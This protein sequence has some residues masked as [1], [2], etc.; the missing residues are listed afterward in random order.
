VPTHFAT[1]RKLCGAQLILCVRWIL[2]RD[3]MEP[4][5][6]TAWLA[7][8][9]KQ[10]WQKAYTEMRAKYIVLLPGPSDKEATQTPFPPPKKQVPAPSGEGPL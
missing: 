1:G 7:E 6:K 8:Q 9:K 3:K 5:V 2:A 4:D 10:A